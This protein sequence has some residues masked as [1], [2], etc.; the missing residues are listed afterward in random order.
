MALENIRERLALFFDAE[1]RIVTSSN[2]QRYRVEIEMPYRP[3]ARP[4]T[5]AERA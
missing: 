4:D 1:A 3:E 5:R 2:G